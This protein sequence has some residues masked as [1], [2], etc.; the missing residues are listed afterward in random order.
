MD[1][2]DKH[3]V[4]LWQK[5]MASQVARAFFSQPYIIDAL[6]H[7]LPKALTYD[8]LENILDI[9]CCDGEWT[10]RL[11]RAYPQAHIIGI[12]TSPDFIKMATQQ[13]EQ[14]HL[15]NVS[16]IK[17]D[18]AQPLIFP[19]ERFDVVH[20]HSLAAFI[21]TAMWARILEEMIR[22]LKPGGWLNIVDYESG[23]YSSRSFE[24]LNTMGM[25]GVR[26]LGGSLS[27]ASNSNGVAARLY[28]FLVDA[29]LIDVSYT[30]HAVD[31]GVNSHPTTRQFLDQLILGMQGF[32]PFLVDLNL[33]DNQTFEVLFAQAQEELY[34][35]DSCGY[36]YL[37]SAIGR[38]DPS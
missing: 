6:G 9:G 2:E 17:F 33:C 7:L 35:P 1:L 31:F 38:K 15:R 22:L 10:R 19:D 36:S 5:G 13:A 11:A 27:P 12:D 26:A 18:S 4:V 8:T 16:F 37:I 28:G 24:Q 32:K 21:T 29:G 3:A 20:I 34:R 25:Q 23:S 14:E 30:I